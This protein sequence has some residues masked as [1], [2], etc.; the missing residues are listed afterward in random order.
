MNEEQLVGNS[1]TSS[2]DSHDDSLMDDHE[3]HDDEE[4]DISSNGK[5]PTCRFCG[6]IFEDR[7]QLNVHYTHTHRDKP[8][9]EC[10]QCQ[11]VFCVKRELSTHQRI[12]SGETPHKCGQCGKE[13]GTR[14]LLKKHNMWHTGERTHV[15]QHCGK[16]FFQVRKFLTTQHNIRKC[17]KM[18]TT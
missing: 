18:M 11:L 12:H 15:C 5:C 1:P 14:Q 7:S 3:N 9:Y 10:D 4:M 17:L 8:Q 2:N 16:A 6:R 13:F